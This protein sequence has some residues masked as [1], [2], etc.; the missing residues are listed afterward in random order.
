MVEC[1]SKFP[2]IGREDVVAELRCDIDRLKEGIG[3]CVILEG[4]PGL[5]KTRLLEE[6]TA[7]ANQRQVAKASG[8]ATE[9][10]HVAPMA[11]LRSFPCGARWSDTEIAGLEGLKIVEQF[12]ERLEAMLGNGPLLVVLDDAQWADELTAL[13][14]RILVPE[15]SSSPVLWV[16]ARRPGPVQGYAQRSIDWLLREEA[17]LLRLEPLSEPQI[18]QLCSVLLRAEP[19]QKLLELAS[20]SGGSPFLVEHL[21]RGLCDSD[22]LRIDKGVA[23]LVDGDLSMDFLREGDRL[24]YNLSDSARW[25]LQAG[26]VLARPFTVEEVANLTGQSPVDT[27]P[28][29]NE[30]VTAGVLVDRGEEFSFRHD[31]I[32]SA[33]YNTLP[34]P[35]RQILHR[36]A[37][38]LLRKE[39]RPS[40]ESALH[41]LRSDTE[42]DEQLLNVLCQA[43]EQMAATSPGAAA[44]LILH[45]FHTLPADHKR[46]PALVADAVRLLATVGRIR[47]AK[48]F[49]EEMLQA[50]MHLIDEGALLMGLADVS[51]LTGDYRAVLR[52]TDQALAISGIQQVVRGRLQALRAHGLLEEQSPGVDSVTA[53]ETAATLAIEEAY[54]TA[55]DSALAC[56]YSGR[57][58]A[59]REKGLLHTAAAF[60]REAVRIADDTGGH[61]RHRHP[62]IWL[63]AVLT[64]ADR[65]EEA[66]ETLMTDQGQS[67]RLGTAWSKPLWHYHMADLRLVAGRLC[68]AKAEAEAG[69]RVAEQLNTSAQNVRLLVLLARVALHQGDLAACRDH[70]ERTRRLLRDGEQHSPVLLTWVVAMLAQ[71][72]GEPDR[73]YTALSALLECD[74]LRMRLLVKAPHAAAHIIGITKQVGAAYN[75]AALLTT[76]QVLEEHNPDVPSIAAAARHAEGAHDEDLTKLHAA[77]QAYRSSPRVL[78]RAMALY[79]TARL[80]A[81]NDRHE[82]VRLLESALRDFDAC[83]AEREAE[84]VRWEL[85]RRGARLGPSEKPVDGPGGVSGLTSSELRVAR[86]V[87]EGLTNREVATKLFLSP[88]TVDS[89][90]RHSFN[91][92]GVNSRV[93][94]TRWVLA[95]DESAMAALK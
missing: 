38:T 76:A 2:M 32:R 90:L 68:E 82:T 23:T 13:A 12:R 48:E 27:L 53:A 87:A 26:S 21:V 80:E 15:L 91:K 85:E 57:C 75:A 47:E 63:S 5:G 56:G 59:A 94:L 62:R 33:M 55:D 7:Y 88:H 79:D 1:P 36:E 17:R 44:D 14:M 18:V 22:R 73:A 67:D 10:D 42:G 19:D 24:L 74:N 43:V 58:K 70:I 40:G 93:E 37:S 69:L 11:T 16:L 3:G 51:Y 28:V 34:G 29:F 46:N 65:L 30:A 64:G 86:L 6:I 66:E 4:A 8:Y 9:L 20:R 77:V 54:R 45:V 50:G 72:E 81:A 49:A 60:A 92:L 31:L 52:Y 78:A 83:G 39:G 84:C 35:V 61:E 89:H 95:N 25:L 41:L 71:A